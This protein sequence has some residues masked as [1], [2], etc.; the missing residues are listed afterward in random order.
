MLRLPGRSPPP[1]VTFARVAA[2]G[3]SRTHRPVRTPSL[4]VRVRATLLTLTPLPTR[5]G[6]CHPVLRPGF[7][8]WGCPKISPPSSL[9]AESVSRPASAERL[10]PASSDLR[11]EKAI[12]IRVPSPWFLTTST[13]FSS[14]TSRPLQ[15]A[16]DPG[17]HHVSFRCETEFL[18]MRFCPSKLS[19]RRQ[20]H[21][22]GDESP[23]LRG[24]A[25]PGRPSPIV[26][27]TAN[28]AP[29]PFFGPRGFA[30]SPGPL[31]VRLFPAVRAR[32]SLGLGRCVRS[33]SCS[34]LPRRE[35]RWSA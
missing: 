31:P 29:S 12:P 28:L 35:R 4:Y 2:R 22:S 11:D 5:S 23:F 20:L 13:V 14:T 8:S 33:P 30:P 7:L 27:F 15:A 9:V 18:A 25:S 24:R 19:L 6:P 10:R 17:V 16:S 26:P 1:S 21:S 32:C 34:A 3:S